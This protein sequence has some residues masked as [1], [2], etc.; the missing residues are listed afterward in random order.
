MLQFEWIWML[1]ALPFP[2]LIRRFMPSADSTEEAALQVPFAEDF[3]VYADRSGKIFSNTSFFLLAAFFWVLLLIAAA[4]PVWLGPPIEIQ[5]S[6]RNLLLA[7]DLSGS[8]QTEDLQLSNQYVTR[9]E[10]TKKV[11]GEFI[12]RRTGDRI[13][14]LLFGTQP[15]LQAPLTFDRK[16]VQTLLNEAA[17]GLAGEK[18]AI[19]DAIGLG[20]KR[21]QELPAKNK[22]IILLTDGANT[23]GTVD[24]EKAAAFA[25]E[26]GITIYTIGVGAD[27]MLV[28]SLFGKRRVNPSAEL[29][30]KT[31]SSIAT[32][33]DGHYFRAKDTSE[34]EKIY[35]LIDDMEPVLTGNQFFRPKSEL[36]V[37][38]L[39]A[40]LLL[41]PLLVLA[42][43]RR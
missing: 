18:T 40:A 30:E 15:Y 16:T 1:A 31:L 27:E 34:L 42:R 36:Y 9:L 12:E 2:F 11:A 26:A 35:A 22:V 41:C 20:V 32:I 14:L 29:D 10:A 37:W 25:K 7:I 28:N 13:G 23:A 33:T 39:G 21:L 24:P 43:G 8:M 4:R 38:P 19:G 17:I 5:V 3:S 6:G